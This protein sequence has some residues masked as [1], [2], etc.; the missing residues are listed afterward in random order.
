V[1]RERAEAARL[2]QD[3]EEELA[4]IVEQQVAVAPDDEHDAEGSTIGFERARVIA[5]LDAARRAVAGLD[6]AEGRIDAGT[7]GRCASCGGPIPDERLAARP[8]ASTC[9]ACASR[10]GGEGGIRGRRP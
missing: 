9:V 4:G 1:R 7:Y 6:E 5:L 2:V 8:T 10:A 3:L